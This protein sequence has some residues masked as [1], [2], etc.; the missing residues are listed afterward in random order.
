[1]RSY[2]CAGFALWVL[3]VDYDFGLLQ[4]LVC[5]LMSWGWVSRFWWVVM[6]ASSVVGYWGKNTQKHL[7]IMHPFPLAM[8]LFVDIVLQQGFYFAF[9]SHSYRDGP[10]QVVLEVIVG[11]DYG[12][13][14][15]YYIYSLELLHASLWRW[16]GMYYLGVVVVF[17]FSKD[18]VRCRD[19][20]ISLCSISVSELNHSSDMHD[21]LP[22]TRC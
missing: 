10:H 12:W 9:Y 11:G 16:C 18:D 8:V 20:K 5:L 3:V 7:C 13:T 17:V 21:C 2:Y 15:L 19:F 1:M 4:V 6:A 14:Y 22:S